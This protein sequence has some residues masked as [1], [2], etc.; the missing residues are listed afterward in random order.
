[1]WLLPSLLATLDLGI[2]RCQEASWGGFLA[3]GLM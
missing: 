1:M 2:E 3:D